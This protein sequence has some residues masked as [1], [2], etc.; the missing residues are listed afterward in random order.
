MCS[1][2][3]EVYGLPTSIDIVVRPDQRRGPT[4]HGHGTRSR[5]PLMRLTTW[6]RRALTPMA[7]IPHTANT[8]IA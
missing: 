2:P 1:P 8:N 3:R 4:T 6:D 5:W 7:A